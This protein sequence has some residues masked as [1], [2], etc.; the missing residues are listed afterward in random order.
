MKN[1]AQRTITQDIRGSPPVWGYV[2]QL[3]VFFIIFFQYSY[4]HRDTTPTPHKIG[5]LHAPHQ[6]LLP[7]AWHST[8]PS[9]NHFR[10]ALQVLNTH[11]AQSIHNHFHLTHWL[12][13]D[14]FLHRLDTYLYIKKGA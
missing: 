4:V 8:E 3:F 12:T 5:Y 6:I 7:R 9:Y 13:T 14:S 2:H 11:Y 10:L 1:I